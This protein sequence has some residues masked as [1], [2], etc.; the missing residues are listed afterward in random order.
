MKPTGGGGGEAD[1]GTRLEED[2]RLIFSAKHALDEAGY[3]LDTSTPLG[4]GGMGIVWPARRRE[5]GQ[6]VA[7]KIFREDEYDLFSTERRALDD[8]AGVDGVIRL[9]AGSPPGRSQ[10]PGVRFLVLERGQG[11]LRDLLAGGPLRPEE[12]ARIAL[13]LARTLNRVHRSR[14][15]HK[16]VK[17][18][19]VLR[20]GDEW[21]LIDFSASVNFRAVHAVPPDRMHPDQDVLRRAD[22]GYGLD[23]RL[24]GLIL[25]EMLVGSI[26]KR[27]RRRPPAPSLF[28]EGIPPALDVICLACLD[29]WRRYQY[30]KAADV[31]D[32]LEEF[33]EDP[34]RQP[35][36]APREPKSVKV[37]RVFT[38]RKIRSICALFLLVALISWGFWKN[39][40][41]RTQ[42]RAIQECRQAI[43]QAKAALE[44][45]K[46]PARILDSLFQGNAVELE[47]GIEIDRIRSQARG[48]TE[49]ARSDLRSARA[50][51]RPSDR[52][53]PDVRRLEDEIRTLDEASLDLIRHYN[54]QDEDRVIIKELDRAR[55][56]RS[57]SLKAA[58][59]GPRFKFDATVDR[60][61]GIFKSHLGVDPTSPDFKA[62][63]LA[64]KLRARPAR[65]IFA[66][67]LI[68]Y[69]Y[70]KGLAL[71]ET[72]ERQGFLRFVGGFR[73]QNAAIQCLRVLAEE[74]DDQDEWTRGFHRLFVTPRNI[75]GQARALT[76]GASVDTAPLANLTILAEVLIE[77]DPRTAVEM[78][79]R[80]RKRAPTDFWV[81]HLMAEALAALKDPRE[82]RFRHLAWDPK[83][84]VPAAEFLL[85][86]A[87]RRNGK[88]EEA[89]QYLDDACGKDKSLNELRQDYKA[90]DTPTR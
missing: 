51:L 60:Y 89:R 10:S 81:N 65:R 48:E 6:D 82:V 25:Y 90:P 33:L 52:A 46:A 19:N 11:T 2:L 41:A 79:E 37:V 43:D 62:D 4:A 68:D 71:A 16:D 56:L 54:L 9:L 39:N 5:D 88:P 78:L 38:S 72:L 53:D 12:A 74:I 77:N 42:A 69:M 28:R 35:R 84:D 76:T 1:V 83:Q 55:L 32:D 13:G 17:P 34:D 15:V 57:P 40:Q 7:V 63:E 44:R 70:C 67:Y 8:L 73:R 58:A 18:S 22:P 80:L 86:E 23:I 64:R 21:K 47:P 24:L 87:L 3:D 75:G 66:V 30:T 50:A 59:D 36:F 31:A 29:P 49:R 20:V 26:P 61:A 27:A 14:I 85:G 45:G